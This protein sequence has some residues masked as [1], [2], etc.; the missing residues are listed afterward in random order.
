MKTA[1]GRSHF[2][3][4][5]SPFYHYF[6]S[7]TGIQL[8]VHMFHQKEGVFIYV[9]TNIFLLMIPLLNWIFILIDRTIINVVFLK[10]PN[11]SYF[12]SGN[13]FIKQFRYFENPDLDYKKLL[14]EKALNSI[15][16][17]SNNET[18]VYPLLFNNENSSYLF[19]EF[20]KWYFT[21]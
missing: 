14:K 6:I 16:L 15:K 17:F 13:Y 20:K 18:E 4:R 12:R 10:S 3:M 5:I 9:V 21:L 19:R 2:Q 1:T 8:T 11:V 7:M